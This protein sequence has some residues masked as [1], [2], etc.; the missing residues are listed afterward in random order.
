[1][2][3]AAKAAVKKRGRPSK[4]NRDAIK[5][6][7]PPALMR[8]LEKAAQS[9]QRPISEVIERKLEQSFEH[10]RMLADDTMAAVFYG[11]VAKIRA[12]KAKAG[13]RSEQPGLIQDQ[14]DLIEAIMDVLVHAMP[15]VKWIKAGDRLGRELT[16]Y[17][18]ARDAEEASSGA[19][20]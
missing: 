6:R 10:D 13:E 15:D 19:L 9:E 1:M 12:G 8:D 20:K 5:F 17:A 14:A 11:L 18:T 7:V 4:G 3:R 2:A 16:V